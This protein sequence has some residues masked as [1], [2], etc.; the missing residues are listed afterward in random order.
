[1]VDDEPGLADPLARRLER[2]HDRIDAVA[3][4]SPLEAL[5]VSDAG[6]DPAVDRELPDVEGPSWAGGVDRVVSDHDVPRMDGLE[7]LDVVRTRHPDLPFVLYAGAGSET[8]ASETVSRGVTDSPRE[9]NAPDR[10]ARLANRIEHA[11]GRRR[12][13]RTPE[14]ERAFDAERTPLDAAVDGSEAGGARVEVR[15]VET[16]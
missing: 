8:P 6:S 14:A 12:A 11:V 5:S 3:V 10:D 15:G 13:E 7:R 1:V 4:T 9:T 2:E 16:L